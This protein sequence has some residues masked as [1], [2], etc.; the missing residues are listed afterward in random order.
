MGKTSLFSQIV[1]QPQ[2]AEGHTQSSM[3]PGK[4]RGLKAPCATFPHSGRLRAQGQASRKPGRL[5]GQRSHD[6]H[7]LEHV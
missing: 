5:Q 2:Q 7:S 6:L 3:K 4:I 1:G